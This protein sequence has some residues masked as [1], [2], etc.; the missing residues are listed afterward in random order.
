MVKLIF[1]L[2]CLLV[3]FGVYEFT[4]AAECVKYQK[5]KSIDIVIGKYCD[6]LGKCEDTDWLYTL[7]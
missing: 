5:I 6:L 2:F 7:S 3:F 4:R 1:F